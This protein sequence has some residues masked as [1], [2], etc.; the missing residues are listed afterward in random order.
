[1]AIGLFVNAAKGLSS[2]QV[3]RNL[4]LHAKTASFDAPWSRS[5]PQPF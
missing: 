2:L 5:S 1:M 3:S 4:G